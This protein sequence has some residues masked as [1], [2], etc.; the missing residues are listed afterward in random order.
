M[1]LRWNGLQ[2]LRHTAAS[3]TDWPVSHSRS[4]EWLVI[5]RPRSRPIAL[6][7]LDIERPTMPRG[8]PAAHRPSAETHSSVRAPT[9]MLVAMSDAS[10]AYTSFIR[11][12]MDGPP[13]A[14]GPGWPHPGE[15]TDATDATL[16]ELRRRAVEPVVAGLLEHGELDELSVH[17]GDAGLPGDVWVRLVVRGETFVQ[18]LSSSAWEGDQRAGV[19]ELAARLADQLADWISETSFGWGQQ[20]IAHYSCP[21]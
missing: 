9:G 1:T 2:A 4:S 15:V 19:A 18:L 13:N 20:R 16:R 5:T 21:E 3:L 11:I 10:E 14:P 7:E 6:D 12:T 8:G 17:W